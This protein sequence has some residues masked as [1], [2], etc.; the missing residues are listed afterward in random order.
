MG[1]GRAAGPGAMAIRYG[2]AP[3]ATL[4]TMVWLDVLSRST[5]DPLYAATRARPAAGATTTSI[6]VPVRGRVVTTVFVAVDTTLIALPKFATY[7]VAPSA[8]TAI[9]DG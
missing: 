8:V 6:G 5:R 7:S 9:P 4:P 3:T 2:K 1:G